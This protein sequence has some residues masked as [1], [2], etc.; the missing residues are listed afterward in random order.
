[1]PTGYIKPS[2]V[3][4]ERA[5]PF[6][7]LKMATRNT[8]PVSF[9][10]ERTTYFD[11][12]IPPV[13]MCLSCQL[14]EYEEYAYFREFGVWK[15]FAP[16]FAYGYR[17]KQTYQGEGM[18]PA[19]AYQ[20]FIDNGI[21]EW[22]DL[23]VMGIY[24]VCKSKITPALIEKAKPQ[25]ALSVVCMF[26]DRFGWGGLNTEQIQAIKTYI[27]TTKM[28]VLFAMDVY[29]DSFAVKADGVVLPL[30]KGDICFGTHAMLIYG[31]QG[32]YMLVKNSYGEKWGLNGDCLVPW[33]YTGWMDFWL[34]T[35]YIAPVIITPPPPPKP[36][37]PPVPPKPP[38]EKPFTGFQWAYNAKAKRLT[39]KIID[40]KGY[41]YTI[42]TNGKK[43]KSKSFSD[44]KVIPGMTATI[45]GKD[46][47]KA[48]IKV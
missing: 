7:A 8:L 44:T 37:D 31:W 3:E 30:A 1:M 9:A 21:C 25:H 46:D 28:P 38:E 39:I 4:R 34:L 13:E 12:R 10:L 15:R 19:L 20:D 22:Q 45:Y 24:P 2:Q 14:S 35:D 42:R 48:I 41:D 47:S 16:A 27:Y 23:P 40:V 17:V 5:I 26:P 43:T 18:T 32:N 29:Q 33:N 6:R 11:Q 36:P